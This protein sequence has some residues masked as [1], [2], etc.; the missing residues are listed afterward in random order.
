MNSPIRP[1]YKEKT[2]VEIDRLINLPTKEVVLT[3]KDLSMQEIVSAF[4]KSTKI[5]L[6]DNEKILSRIKKARR[7][8][9]ENVVEGIPVYGTNS[10]F[11]GQAHRVLNKGE[12]EVRLNNA[13]KISEGLV[14]LDIGVGPEVPPEI[15]KAAMTIRINM[16]MQGV[17]GVRLKTL[18]LYRS[19]I[20]NNIIPVVNSYGG[21]GASGDLAHNQRIVSALRGLHGIKVRNGKD[22]KEEAK[23]ALVRSGIPLLELDPKEGLAL[24]NGDNFSTA[25]AAFIIHRLIEYFLIGEVVGAMAIEVLKGST[26]SFHPMLAAVRPHAGQKESADTYRHLLKGSQL[27]YQELTG[28]QLRPDGIKVQDGYSLRSL[29]QF[30]AVMIEKIKWALDVITVNANSVSDNPLWVPDEFAT[31]GEE[32]W[33]WVSG[34]NFLAMHMA[35]VMDNMRKIITQMVKRNDRHLAR[36]IDMS[37][38]NGLGAN[39]SSTKSIT[40]C[41]F[42]GIQIQSGMLEIYSMILANPVTTLFGVHEERNQD[43]T[44]HAITSGILALKNLELLNYSLVSNLLAVA[45]G[46]DLRGGPELLSPKTRPMYEFVRKFSEKVSEDRPLFGDIQKLSATLDDGSMM[47]VVREQI[48]NDNNI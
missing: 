36:M 32:P 8:V 43:I 16:L 40:R 18:N 48:F 4:N 39:L 5:K 7:V 38:N 20:N 27:A 21:I 14:F 34:G 9:I 25:Y 35:E 17:S 6:T 3:G 47:K 13:R 15:V 42:K 19:V 12:L 46:V 22:R 33:Q 26:R 41:T 2:L 31:K 24:V 30:E 11:G 23:S 45:Q 28:H 29:S 37:E 44:S 10:S 1:S